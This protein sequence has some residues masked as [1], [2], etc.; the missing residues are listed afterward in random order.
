MDDDSGAPSPAL[1]TQCAPTHVSQCES[2]HCMSFPMQGP[3]PQAHHQ[4]QRLQVCPEDR[5]LRA[6]PPMHPGRLCCREGDRCWEGKVAAGCGAGR[7]GRQA[8]DAFLKWGFQQ[9]VGLTL[10]PPFISKAQGEGAPPCPCAPGFQGARI[11]QERDGPPSVGRMIKRLGLFTGS[12]KDQS[13]F[14][15]GDYRPLRRHGW[16]SEA[17]QAP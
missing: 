4:P 3:R 8:A 17:P 7:G 11:T 15:I 9:V 6:L 2:P 1:A 5:G 14:R 13:T 12:C 10:A 16:V